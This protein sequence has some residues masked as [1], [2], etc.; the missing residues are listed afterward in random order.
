[1][2]ILECNGVDGGEEETLDNWEKTALLLSD[3]PLV[4]GELDSKRLD[5]TDLLIFAADMFGREQV[6]NDLGDGSSGSL[7]ISLFESLSFLFSSSLML[8][9]SLNSSSSDEIASRNC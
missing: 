3:T 2:L 9:S 5:V 7:E 4:P 6:A 1:L 8:K